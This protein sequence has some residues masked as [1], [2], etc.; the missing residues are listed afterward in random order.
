MRTQNLVQQRQRLRR[1]FS[2]TVV[3]KPQEIALTS[4]DE[5][6]LQ[7]I[8]ATLDVQL[9]KEQFS[10]EDLAASVGM[11]RSQLQRKLTALIDQPPVEFIRNFRL[12]R[13]KEM[14]EAGAGNVSEIC[15]EVGLG[16]PAYFSKA[17]KEAFGMSPSEVR[18]KR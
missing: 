4:T 10:V 13:A 3:L 11:S 8:Q 1:Q 2:H 16:S 5:R 6:F 9:G 7:R 17:F 12:R 18:R 15:Y 14:L